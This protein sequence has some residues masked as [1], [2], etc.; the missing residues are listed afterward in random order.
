MGLFFLS[1]QK[2]H[3]CASSISK[4]I[5]HQGSR[6]SGTKTYAKLPHEAEYN[7]IDDRRTGIQAVH[8]TI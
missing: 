1:K 2:R 6:R 4:I 7:G 8:S 5:Y 3:V